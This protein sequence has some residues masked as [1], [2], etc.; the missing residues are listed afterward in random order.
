MNLEHAPDNRV[1]SAVARVVPGDEDAEQRGAE[2]EH[3]ADGGDASGTRCLVAA[4]R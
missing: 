3:H 2:R 1:P 4:G